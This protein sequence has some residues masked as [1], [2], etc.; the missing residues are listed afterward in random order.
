MFT[1]RFDFIYFVDIETTGLDFFRNEILTMSLSVCDRELN[2]IDEAD[3]CFKPKNEAWSTEAENIHK[4]TKDIAQLFNESDS[5]WFRFL[6][7]ISKYSKKRDLMVCHALWM[8]KYFDSAFIDAQLEIRD[9]LF[10]KRKYIEATISTI[11]MEKSIEK[12]QSYSLNNA[13]K[14]YNIELDHHNAKSDREACQKL[15]KLILDKG[16]RDENIYN[17][18][19]NENSSMSKKTKKSDSKRSNSEPVFV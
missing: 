9:L 19:Q 11:S 10:H 2:Q 12:H 17:T 3:F 16:G 5:E 13:C 15:F 14:R 1:S 6:S 7:F 18:E 8:G 4:I